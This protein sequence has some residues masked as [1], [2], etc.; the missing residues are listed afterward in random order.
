MSEKNFVTT[1]YI[2]NSVIRQGAILG[3]P[4]TFVDFNKVCVSGFI[5]EEFEYSHEV[6][7]EKFYKT[8]VGVARFS[9]TEDYV[10]IIVSE[11]LMTSI[12]EG[13]FKGKYIHVEGQLRSYNKAGKDGRRH[14]DMFLFARNI[15]VYEIEREFEYLLP[16]EN[17]IYLDGHICRQPTFRTTPF[18]R[19]ITDFILAVNRAHNKADYIPCITWGRA[20]QYA[21]KLEV[22]DWIKLYGRVQSRE[23]L[24]KLPDSENV[25][26]RTTYEVSIMRIMKMEG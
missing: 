18:G 19:Q 22:G 7:R 26:V 10:P 12:P 1:Q 2:N 8:R 11:L 21:S 23:Y 13:G 9:G 5:E 3:K 4:N 16:N 14:L 25:E 17:L 15:K 6:L 20:A 24:K